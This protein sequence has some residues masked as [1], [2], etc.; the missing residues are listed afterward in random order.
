MYTNILGR[1]DQHFYGKKKCETGTSLVVQW[2][3]YYTSNAGVA[4]SNPGWGMKIQPAMQPKK[5]KFFKG[6]P[7]GSEIKN[8]P[9][10]DKGHQ[11]NP[12]SGKTPH[13]MEQLSL[14]ATATEPAPV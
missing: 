10:G 6:F 1:S 9:A 4:G 7:G 14:C 3:R 11:F 13:A 12:W 8:L 5:K 2:L